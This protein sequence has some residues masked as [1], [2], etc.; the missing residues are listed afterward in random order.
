ML[1]TV[2]LSGIVLG[3]HKVWTHLPTVGV[4]AHG[5]LVEGT[6]GFSHGDTFGSRW[7][8]KLRITTAS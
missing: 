4:D 2:Y 3:R 5:L 6:R 1:F 8:G 7:R